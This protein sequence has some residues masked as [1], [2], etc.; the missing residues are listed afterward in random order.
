MNEKLKVYVVG[1]YSAEDEADVEHNVDAAIRMGE[2]IAE[3]GLVPFIPHLFH[4]W[5]R[6]YPHEYEFWMD[7][8]MEWMLMCDVL[9]RLPGVSP[10]GDREEAVAKRMGMKVYYDLETLIREEKGA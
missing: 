4:F 3:A 8:V 2:H 10:G 1:P 6:C 9:I 7:Q 5:G